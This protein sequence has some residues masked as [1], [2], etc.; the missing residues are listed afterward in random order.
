MICKKHKF[1]F[2]HI[3]KCAGTSIEM[4]F[5]NNNIIDKYFKQD[6][7]V[8]HDDISTDMANSFF[9]FAVKR[10]PWER[11]VSI[12]KYWTGFTPKNYPP[13]TKALG[14]EFIQISLKNFA[15]S[16]DKAR[17]NIKQNWPE[18]GCHFKEMVEL[19]GLPDYVNVDFW[20]EFANLQ[21]DFDTVCDKIGI[22][23]Q[24]I[25][26]TNKSKHKHYTKYYD[27][28]TRAIVAERH[29]RDIEYFGYEFGE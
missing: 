6:V 25:P 1:I 9:T 4:C 3:P 17:A 2:I 28:E 11:F 5:K 21:E 24:Q 18:Q 12:W 19:N 13:R 26:H 20:I 23:R 8:H 10:N 14:L 7:M 29:A 27:D 16:L 15:K 22:P